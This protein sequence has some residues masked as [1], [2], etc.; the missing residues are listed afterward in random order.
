LVTG[1]L[2]Q[3]SLSF[4]TDRLDVRR[5]DGQH[6]L[7][8]RAVGSSPAA[9]RCRRADFAEY[10]AWLE[11]HGVETGAVRISA[12]LRTARFVYTTDRDQNQIA[13]FY[14]GAMA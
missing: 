5:G 11:A 7:R 13:T 6:L 1:R 3:V 12:S 8:S 4:L 10:R 2:H 14:G 9:G